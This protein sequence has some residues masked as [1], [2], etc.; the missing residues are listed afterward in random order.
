M[1]D[2]E[3]EIE[4]LSCGEFNN[5]P[6]LSPSVCLCL[7]PFFAIFPTRYDLFT[8]LCKIDQH[9]V[10]FVLIPPSSLHNQKCS[11]SAE[12]TDKKVSKK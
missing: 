11:F 10:E 9:E 12:T 2:V 1:N 7:S 3:G 6:Q 4:R 5:F 8:D